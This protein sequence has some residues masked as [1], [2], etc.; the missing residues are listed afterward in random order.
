MRFSLVSIAKKAFETASAESV[1][2]PTK[3]GIVTIL[4]GHEP[5]MSAL[6]PGVLTVRAEGRDHR[7]GVGGGA[8]ETD[9]SEV[10]VLADLVEDGEGLNAEDAAK[11]KEE[12]ARL[13]KEAR[14]SGT[15]D[16]ASLIALEEEYMKEEMRVKLAE[17]TI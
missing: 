9:G 3:A 2:V 10:T 7:F 17:G 13:L 5:L 15:T 14:A 12:A 4:P 16:M 1:T 8:L 6:S 11:R